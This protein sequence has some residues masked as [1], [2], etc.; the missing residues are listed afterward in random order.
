MSNGDVTGIALL[1]AFH[2]PDNWPELVRVLERFSPGWWQREW[3]K[4]RIGGVIAERERMV[5]S[6]ELELRPL[7]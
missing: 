5:E 6:G 2:A 4:E 7:S 1:V 3:C